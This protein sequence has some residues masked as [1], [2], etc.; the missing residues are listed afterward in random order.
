M[1][2]AFGFLGG[3]AGSLHCVAMCGVFPVA[4]R[5]GAA[6]GNLKRQL[7]YNVGRLNTL[8]FVGAVSGGVGAALV[9]SVPVR[10]FERALAILAGTFMVLIGCEMLGLVRGIAAPLAA[11][12]Q[13]SLVR[14]LSGVM[15]ASSAVAP[16]ALGVL[17]AF[18]P[19]HLIYAFAARAAASA[20]ALDG[21]LLMLSFGLGT[22]PAMLL[23]GT[24]SLPADLRLRRRVAL[25]SALLVIGFGIV[26][27]LRG[28]SPHVAHVH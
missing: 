2:F 28:V 14:W 18:L 10:S 23:M 8:L 9:A 17:N 15:S 3:V 4:L 1:L 16:L 21:A 27:L 6:T 24:V 11:Y 7:L 20:S 19:C 13:T 26:T 12:V 22:V 5:H 25:A